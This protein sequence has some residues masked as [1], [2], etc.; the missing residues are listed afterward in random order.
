[1]PNIAADK[2][3]PRLATKLARALAWV[4]SKPLWF[5]RFRG[6]ENIPPP[7]S[8]ALLVAANHQTFVDP[9]WIGI[10]MRHDLRFMAWDE[11]FKWR[12][13]GP[14][15]S[16]LG[17][18]PVSLESGGTIKAMKEALRALR[19]GAALVVFPEAAREL[20][21]GDLLP[22]K[23]GVVRIALQANVPILPVTIIG[24]NRIW[25]R[26]QK[27]PRFFRRVTIIYHPLLHVTEDE[28][29]DQHE[30]LDRWTAKLKDI[31]KNA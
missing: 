16:Y 5:I 21:D 12:F 31:I 7:D 30:N 8:G 3:P 23:T 20:A 26:D 2:P 1:V 9:A 10:P 6:R 27:F 14:L 15:I 19:N 24:G 25:P 18:F 29:I 4:I 22:F 28:S 13:I 17:A 11:A